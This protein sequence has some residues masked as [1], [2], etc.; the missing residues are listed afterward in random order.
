LIQKNKNESFLEQA[1]DFFPALDTTP[2]AINNNPS[3]EDNDDEFLKKALKKS[4]FQENNT[5][6][7]KIDSKL[8][9]FSK[10]EKILNSEYNNECSKSKHCNDKIKFQSDVNNTPGNLISNSEYNSECSKSKHCNDKIKFQ[11]NINNTLENLIKTM[12]RTEQSRHLLKTITQ[13][14]SSNSSCDTIRHD[15]EKPAFYRRNSL[16]SP[17]LTVINHMP[18]SFANDV[19]PFTNTMKLANKNTS[20]SC[21]KSNRKSTK[22]S[23]TSMRGSRRGKPIGYKNRRNSCPGP[24]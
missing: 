5:D 8:R 18:N 17:V 21:T 4:I 24:T 9:S 2:R 22:K 1:Y 11:S 19:Y 16:D 6:P 15:L 23:I 7:E 14:Q 3:D 13:K 10:R 20:T 12:K